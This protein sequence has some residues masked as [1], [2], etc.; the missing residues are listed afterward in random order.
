MISS[1]KWSLLLTFTDFHGICHLHIEKCLQV[2]RNTHTR[3]AGRTE[4]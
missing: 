2:S 3:P 1:N 4:N